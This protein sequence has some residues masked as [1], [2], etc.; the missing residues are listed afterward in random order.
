MQ[1]PALIFH[2]SYA[3]IARTTITLIFDLARTHGSSDSS[4][5]T[6]RN[7][8]SSAPDMAEALDDLLGS[9]PSSVAERT[10]HTKLRPIFDAERI[11]G[12]LYP[13]T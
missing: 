6:L 7:E 12:V 4:F 8:I 9:A 11:Q 13:R 2:P 1:A 5:F 3:F 10:L